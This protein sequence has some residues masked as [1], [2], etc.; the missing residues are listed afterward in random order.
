MVA[1]IQ[2]DA[3]NEDSTMTRWH[4]DNTNTNTREQGGRHRLSARS[5]RRPPS[6][7]GGRL[8]FGSHG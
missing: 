1:I 4:G 8:L 5:S 2:P 3:D 7:G 6:D